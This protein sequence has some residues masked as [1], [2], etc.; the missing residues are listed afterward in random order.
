MCGGWYWRGDPVNCLRAVPC[1]K[2]TGSVSKV[3][4]K[5]IC[6]MAN[7]YE[8]V[9]LNLQAAQRFWQLRFPRK[10]LCLSICDRVLIRG[11]MGFLDR[12]ECDRM[13]VAVIDTGSF[14]A[15]AARLS[16]S[17]GQASKLV[18]RLERTSA[19]S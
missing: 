1:T 17:N 4:Q 13:F 2:Y 10:L 14:A 3:P 5:L 7:G 19:C 6:G 12:I 11:W 18:S 16:T 15:A 9:C 8:R